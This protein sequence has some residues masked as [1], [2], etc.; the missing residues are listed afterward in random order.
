MKKISIKK[1]QILQQKG[2]YKSKLYKVESGLLRSYT[3]SKGGKEHIFMFSP[4]GWM[5]GD[6]I[7]PTEPCELF[8]DAL[9]NSEVFI[10]E[11]DK[12]IRSIDKITL[13]NR[14]I[15]MQRRIILLI[16]ATAYDRYEDFIKTYPSIVPR[17]PQKMIASYLGV[18]PEALSKVKSD[19]YKKIKD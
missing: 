10:I 11:K 14:I 17:V 16:G 18:T 3:I 9:E 13:R 2:D 7:P 8:I 1:G 15:A 12:D 6:S 5:I 19:H 4:E